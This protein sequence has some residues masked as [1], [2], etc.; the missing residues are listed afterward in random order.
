M[1]FLFPPGCYT[2]FGCHLNCW[3]LKIKIKTTIYIRD[4][5]NPFHVPRLRKKTLKINL[6]IFT[7]YQLY[8]RHYIHSDF[9]FFK[10]KAKTL[11]HTILGFLFVCFLIWGVRGREGKK[12]NKKS[13][14]DNIRPKVDTN[15]HLSQQTFYW[16][17]FFQRNRI[18]FIQQILLST[19]YI[20]GRC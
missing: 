16:R 7:E 2:S 15:E 10:K 3:W 19:R 6:K 11:L 20:S 5:E 8:S 9:F 4:Y 14:R 12:R 1:I 18:P 13:N 17:I